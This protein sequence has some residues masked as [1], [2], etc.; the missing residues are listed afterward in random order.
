M[1]MRESEIGRADY[2]Q[3]IL[4]ESDV[5][6]FNYYC[7]NDRLDVNPR[8]VERDVQKMLDVSGGRF[9]VLQ[10]MGCPA[11]FDAKSRIR[12]SE[13][14]Q[15]NFYRR[16][17]EAIA[18]EPRIRAAFAF[19]LVDWSPELVHY[20]DPILEGLPQWFIASFRETLQTIGLCRYDD[21]TCRPALG[22]FLEGV[23][24]LSP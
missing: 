18:A 9:I 3:P 15:R 13:R 23:D 5:A 19:G 1:T 17:I 14:K 2:L 4:S 22:V 10:E 6:C 12:G 16:M 20:F 8:T 7:Q 11:G 21:G 24:R